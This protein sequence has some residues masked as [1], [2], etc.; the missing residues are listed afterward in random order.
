MV[1]VGMP[2]KGPKYQESDIGG[3]LEDSGLCQGLMTLNHV[4]LRIQTLGRRTETSAY[5]KKEEQQAI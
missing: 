3:K 4:R 1:G 2:V 5:S